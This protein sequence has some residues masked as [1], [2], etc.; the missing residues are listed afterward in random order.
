MADNVNHPTHYTGHPSGVECIDIVEHL[1]FN[2]GNAI[3][4]LW[5]RDD[6]GRALEDTKK[7]LWY[8]ERELERLHH[9]TQIQAIPPSAFRFMVRVVVGEAGTPMTKALN[10]L[11]GP[12]RDYDLIAMIEAVDFMNAAVR[13]DLRCR[14]VTV[15]Q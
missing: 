12:Q 15:S 2:L 4:Y 1:S 9:V 11:A 7:A 14:P 5:R 13:E 10:R 3:K 6:K 8:L